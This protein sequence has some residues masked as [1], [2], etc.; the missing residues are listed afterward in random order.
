LADATSVPLEAATTS[1]HAV[2]RAE[3]SWVDEVERD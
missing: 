1:L 2:E 3:C